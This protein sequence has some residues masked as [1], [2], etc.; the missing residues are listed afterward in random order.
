M[1][2]MEINSP[3]VVMR[4]PGLK[5]TNSIVKP[6]PEQLY[7]FMADEKLTISKRNDEAKLRV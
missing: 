6:K 5:T 7:F 4:W 3:Q 2:A 1:F